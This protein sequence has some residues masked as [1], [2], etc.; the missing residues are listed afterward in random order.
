MTG[1]G[2]A[3]ARFRFSGKPNLSF[4][5]GGV[6]TDL[7]S[8]TGLYAGLARDG[9]AARPRLVDADPISE[10]FLMSPGA[11]FIVRQMLSRSFSRIP[12]G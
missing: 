3:G 7:A 4:I 8:I 1:S 11:A 12:A 5:L 9:I 2:N 6:G 10:R